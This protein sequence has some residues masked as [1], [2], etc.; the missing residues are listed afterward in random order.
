MPIVNIF[1]DSISFSTATN[2]WDDAALTTPSADG[3]YSELGIYREKVSG[4]LG[5]VQ[6]CPSCLNPVACGTA[7]S[8]SGNEG[9]Y[10]LSFSVGTDTGAIV[11]KFFPSNI[12]DKCAWT[13]DGVTASEYSCK[14]F[15]YLEGIIGNEA[16]GLTCNSSTQPLTN[17]LGSNGQSYSGTLWEYN[18]ATFID[19]TAPVT[20]GP[21]PASDVTLTSADPGWAY[22][23]IPK[24]NASPQTVS[25]LIDAMCG[26]TG[27]FLEIYCPRA[28]DVRSVGVDDGTCGVYSTLMYSCSV[29]DIA[30]EDGSSSN[31]GLHDWVFADPNGVTQF[32]AGRYPTLVAGI[33][34]CIT[35]STDGII[36]AIDTCSGNCA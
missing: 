7:I 9:Q 33:E 36:T 24:P 29:L 8:A 26:T 23:V 20:M 2:V 3:W 17:A 4:V 13:F 1:Y 35:V 11:V 18:G 34:S 19:T 32:P 5:P 28:L 10:A 12:P 27:W 25:L 31:L 16:Q 22:M 14:S 30:G 6:T 21:Y 15:G